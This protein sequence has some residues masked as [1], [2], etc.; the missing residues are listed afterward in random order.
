MFQQSIHDREQFPHGG[1]EGHLGRL[2]R[3]AESAIKG[4]EV[5]IVSSGTD[6]R[7]I[8][9]GSHRGAAAP[10]MALAAVLAAIAVHRGDADEGGDGAPVERPQFGQLGEKRPRGNRADPRDAA[11]Q[12]LL[13]SPHGTGLNGRPDLV[14][15]VVHAP[16]EPANVIPQIARDAASG[17]GLLEAAALHADHL[18][19][20]PPPR[21]QRRERLRRGI[22]E[23]PRRRLHPRPERGEDVRIDGVGLGGAAERLRE[24]PHLPWIDDRDRQAHRGARGDQGTLIPAGRFDDDDRRRYALQAGDERLDRRRCGVA[25]PSLAGRGDGND[26]RGFAHIDADADCIHGLAPPCRTSRPYASTGSWPGQLSGIVD[27]QRGRA[28]TL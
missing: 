26:K 15:H 17:R 23:R 21:D 3:G 19:Q 27:T 16:F 4:C 11:Q 28:P 14:V 12:I 2:P 10:D 6:R 5:G 18:D 1:D 20:L 7:H 13:D 24:G 25:R 22:G 8:Q 9:G